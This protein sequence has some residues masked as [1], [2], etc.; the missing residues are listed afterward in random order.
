MTFFMRTEEA[1]SQRPGTSHPPLDSSLPSANQSSA[2]GSTS[3]IRPRQA[4]ADGDLN[5]LE[6]V[7]PFSVKTGGNESQSSSSPSAGSLR[8][9]VSR[10]IDPSTLS[11]VEFAKLTQQLLPIYLKGFMHDK[12]N[13]PDELA[14]FTEDLMVHLRGTEAILNLTDGKTSYGFVC[15]SLVDTPFGRTYHLTGIILDPKI[16]GRN[17]A[18]RI[19]GMELERTGAKYLAFHTQSQR[20]KRLGGRC[21]RLSTRRS[22]KMSVFFSHRNLNGVVDIG[23]YHGQSLYGDMDRFKQMAIPKINIER[24]DALFF[25]GRVRRRLK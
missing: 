17:I 19:L 4:L 18:R 2:A 23:R 16:E 13:S 14:R 24:G 7:T 15:S 8:S 20:M 21:A 6:M 1:Q 10:R 9:L 11:D 12:N 25:A 3:G 5:S 22:K